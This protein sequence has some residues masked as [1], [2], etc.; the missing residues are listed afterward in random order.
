MNRTMRNSIEIVASNNAIN[1]MVPALKDT[2]I[3]SFSY[4][5]MAQDFKNGVIN[6]SIW[7]ELL[8]LDFG[9][10]KKELSFPET[11]GCSIDDDDYDTVVTGK[12][13]NNTWAYMK[14][15]GVNRAPLAYVT[16]LVLYYIRKK[17]HDEQLLAE[18]KEAVEVGTKVK[19]GDLNAEEASRLIR[20]NKYLNLLL[21]TDPVSIEKIKQIDEILEEVS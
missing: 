10:K 5:K 9:D 8:K 15:G 2:E 4:R 3:I 16:K 17:L 12:D 21:H 18:N 19:L 7:D 11:R 6:G 20:L 13:K 1:E 14:R